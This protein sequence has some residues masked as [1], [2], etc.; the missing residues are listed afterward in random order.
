[1]GCKGVFVT[2]TCFRDEIYFASAL[3]RFGV[4]LTM[5]SNGIDSF[6]SNRRY[7]EKL[8]IKHETFSFLEE[9]KEKQMRKKDERNK[10]KQVWDST[11]RQLLLISPYDHVGMVSYFKNHTVHVQASWRRLTSK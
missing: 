1:M 7:S 10:A 5:A 6:E 3:Y 4:C 11:P 2:G 8:H 9:K